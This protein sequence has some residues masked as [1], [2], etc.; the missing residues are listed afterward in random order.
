[1][2][3][4]RIRN[5]AFQAEMTGAMRIFTRLNHSSAGWE[6]GFYC[7][8][9]EYTENWGGGTEIVT[10]ETGHISFRQQLWEEE[11]TP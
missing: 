3:A 9:E 6:N 1:L 7:A 8:F 2:F 10:N 5:N 11:Q 4:G